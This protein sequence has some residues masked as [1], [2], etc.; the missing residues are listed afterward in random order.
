MCKDCFC[1][2]VIS[3]GAVAEEGTH[4]SLAEAGGLYS[5]LV[6]HLFSHD[7]F[8][9][10]KVFSLQS[11]LALPYGGKFETA[12]F[13]QDCC[14]KCTV[15]NLTEVILYAGSETVCEN[16]IVSLT[17]HHH[18]W[19]LIHIIACSEPSG[20]SKFIIISRHHP[21]VEQL[22]CSLTDPYVCRSFHCRNAHPFSEWNKCNPET[23]CDAVSILLLLCCVAQQSFPCSA[24]LLSS[25][26]TIRS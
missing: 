4:E 19:W 3:A 6:H 11:R 24:L 2:R 15:Q 18:A 25:E 23:Y 12:E 5:A 14:T 1:C 20:T 13:T 21:L 7:M 17:G 16:S 10:E 22:R 8:L 9:W 26:T